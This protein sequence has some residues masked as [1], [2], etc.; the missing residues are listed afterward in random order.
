ML[1]ALKGYQ[2]Y[3]YFHFTCN[4]VS[5]LKRKVISSYKF[6]IFVNQVTIKYCFQKTLTLKRLKPIIK[7]GNQFI[8][9]KLIYKR[10]VS[11][12]GSYFPTG[13]H[14]VTRALIELWVRVPVSRMPGRCLFFMVLLP[15]KRMS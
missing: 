1:A 5:E 2:F 6:L 11:R 7:F 12:V 3:M 10:I 15:N 4:D 8:V 13:G 14:S 9:I